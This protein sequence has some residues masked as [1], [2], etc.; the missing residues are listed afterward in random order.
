[1]QRIN[2]IDT[3]RGA[4][5]W[6]MIY[7]HIIFWW[8]RPEDY[9][10]RDWLFAFLK[11]L[12]ATGFLFISGVSTALAFKNSQYNILTSDKLKMLTVRNVFVIRAIMILLIGFIFNLF[13][14]VL[15]GGNNADIWSW[16][17]LQTIGFSLLFSWPLLKTSKPFRITLGIS[18]IIANQLILLAISSSKGEFNL[19]GIFYH[20]LYNP[21]DQ[22]VILTYFGVFIIGTVVGETIFKLNIIDDQQKKKSLFKNKFLI[23]TFLIGILIMI[24]GILFQFPNFL[25]FGTISSIAYSVGLIL[26][27]LS[28]LMVIEILE[29]I[30]VKK[31]YKY[32]FFYSYYSFS[33]YIA[34]NLLFFLF[35]EQLHFLIA[36]LVV[37]IGNVLFG[38]LL[39][40]TYKKLGP[41]ASLKSGISI[42]SFIIVTRIKGEKPF[43]IIAKNEK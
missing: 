37:V 30:K 39:R 29:K 11:P 19:F 38:L 23:P 21:V 32:L 2:S 22:Y 36:I 6:I 7:G 25:F 10:F 5:M 4:S 33:I 9:W 20:L 1:M 35:L 13:A 14:A 17:V 34:H 41:K 40:T 18:L 28:G 15:W 31:S 42:L 3:I 24:S 12:G 8:L 26:A 16:N 43:K 27:A